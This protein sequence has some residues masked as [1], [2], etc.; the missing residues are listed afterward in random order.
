MHS[1]AVLGR[2]EAV[3]HAIA[4]GACVARL[5][6]RVHGLGLTDVLWHQ[7]VRVTFRGTWA[8]AVPLWIGYSVG[9]LWCF[10]S[11]PRRFV[12]LFVFL[13]AH[14]SSVGFVFPS[15][16]VDFWCGVN[17]C[18]NSWLAGVALRCLELTWGRH[19]QQSGH[20]VQGL[21]LSLGV[22]AVYGFK[23]QAYCAKYESFSHWTR[24]SHSLCHAI[25]QI[26]PP[27]AI[28]PA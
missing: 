14:G 18:L 25:S 17:L 15:F 11:I 4:P 12:C 13:H 27:I 16:A 2:K 19:L 22:M 5:G 9:A 20:E 6:F 21:A 28:R 26:R 1:G 24:N 10:C 7:S 3:T 23:L 8:T